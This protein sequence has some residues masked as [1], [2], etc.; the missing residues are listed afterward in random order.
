MNILQFRGST[1]AWLEPSPG[2]PSLN[3][4]RM[5]REGL[6]FEL[7][8]ALSKAKAN[9][10]AETKEHIPVQVLGVQKRVTLEVIPLPNTVE[11]YYL[12][13]FRDELPA[14]E[15]KMATENLSNP[16]ERQKSA[17]SE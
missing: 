11:P 3:I 12:I 9:N 5:A 15:A 4:L 2:K 1:G 8:N 17:E 16:S 7:R 10:K 14:S 6:S 13:L